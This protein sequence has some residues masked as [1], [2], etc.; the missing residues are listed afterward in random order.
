M[1][2]AGGGG[3][4]IVS[5]G[6]WSRWK[7][8]RYPQREINKE[9]F[10]VRTIL[11]VD[12]EVNLC[13]LYEKELEEAGYN[14]VVTHDGRKAVELVE[15]KGVD[16]VVLDIRMAGQDGID[17][18]HQLMQQRRDLPVILNTAYSTYRMDFN[19]W[20]AD[21]YVIKS[22]DLTELKDKIQELLA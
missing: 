11:V 2:A 10:A 18:L 5:S 3:E 21:A 4:V 22:S 20:L 8:R 17:T 6:Q 15:K 19:T 16:L 13:R 1:R 12:D 14:V 9:V 7:L